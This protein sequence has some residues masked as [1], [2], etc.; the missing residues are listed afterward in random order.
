MRALSSGTVSKI[1]YVGYLRLLSV[2]HLCIERL[3]PD[4]EPRTD[5]IAD[6]WSMFSGPY[7]LLLED[8]EHFR[9][10]V[11]PDLMA[12]MN[13]GPTIVQNMIMTS[14]ASPSVRVGY[15]YVLDT[16]RPYEIPASTICESLDLDAGRGGSYIL[17]AAANNE[18]RRS[19]FEAALDAE[20]VA[21]DERAAMI[22]GAAA[23]LAS[24]ESALRELEPFTPESLG[25]HVTSLNPEA[26]AHPVTQ[27]PLEVRAALDATDRCFAEHG[28]FMDRYGM[29]GRRFTDSDGAWLAYLVDRDSVTRTRRVEWLRRMLSARGMPTWILQLHLE[30]LADELTRTK[31]ESKE[32]YRVLLQEAARLDA[33]IR[34]CIPL[35]TTLA[36]VDGF[37]ERLRDMRSGAH[38][39]ELG[40]LLVEAVIDEA[41]GFKKAVPSVYEWM[42]DPERFSPHWIAAV[43]ELLAAARSVAGQGER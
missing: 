14:A 27:D 34:S 13:M 11:V 20:V 6:M 40:R 31:P 1:G 2:I 23:L 7:A 21:S 9:L 12:A 19:E 5:V 3:V 42:V 22:D 8:L 38:A 24:L 26:G 15:L 28:Y 37:A 18:R 10:Q 16:L 25:I 33:E 39:A 17:D 30:I 32:R 41:S 43:D 4:A 35:E 36:L 29:R